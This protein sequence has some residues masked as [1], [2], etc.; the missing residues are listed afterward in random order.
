LIN[1]SI[2]IRPTLLF[3]GVVDSNRVALPI[4]G[5]AFI[6]TFMQGVGFHNADNTAVGFT[7]NDNDA[8]AH[9]GNNGD[10]YITVGPGVCFVPI[11]G[12]IPGVFADPSASIIATI[13]GY[14]WT[15][16]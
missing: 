14:F 10:H 12:D 3:S 15:D 7:I 1:D 4:T 9:Q 13:C 8:F 11:E 16:A 6:I 5:G 2:I